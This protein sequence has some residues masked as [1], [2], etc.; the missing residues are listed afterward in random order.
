MWSKWEVTTSGEYY[1]AV[2]VEIEL[3]TKQTALMHLGA[4][5]I[6]IY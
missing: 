6:Q 4:V 1:F 3:N 2:N 5:R